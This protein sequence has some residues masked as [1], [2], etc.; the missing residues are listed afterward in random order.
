M[1]ARL[2][3]G[4]LLSRQFTELP[5]GTALAE[6]AR[7]TARAIVAVLILRRLAGSRAAMDRLEHVGAVLL[8]V[9]VGEG[10][11]ASIAMLALRAAT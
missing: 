9:A 6:T 3:S 4:D 10:L 2:C 11:S 5:L 7:N 1:V 8:A